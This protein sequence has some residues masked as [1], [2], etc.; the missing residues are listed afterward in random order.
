MERLIDTQAKQL[1]EANRL[2]RQA[3]RSC[4]M[5][6]CRANTRD[7]QSPYCGLHRGIWEYMKTYI[8]RSFNVG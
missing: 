1:E 2:L 7:L 8:Y 3:F 4:P 5:P 6:S